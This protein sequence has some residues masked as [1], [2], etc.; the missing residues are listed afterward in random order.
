VVANIADVR[1]RE[2]G[3]IKVERVACAVDCGVAVNPDVIKAQMEGGLGYGLGAG[4]KGAI[5]LLLHVREQ[6]WSAIARG[7]RPQWDP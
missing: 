3:T 5:T 7:R 2:D 6:T 1:L 4:L